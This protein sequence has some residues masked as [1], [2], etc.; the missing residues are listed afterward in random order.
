MSKMLKSLPG[1]IALVMLLPLF[2]QAQAGSGAEDTSAYFPMLRGKKIGVVAN[3]ASEVSGVNI[4]DFL[5]GKGFGIKRIFSPEHGFRSAAEAGQHT[6]D[7]TDPVTGI[8]V[9]SLY[10]QKRKPA[11]SDLDDLDLVVFDIQDVG[12]RFY[13]FISTMLLSMEAAAELHIPFIVLD[14]PNPINGV[15]MEGAILEY[16]R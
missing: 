12:A 3:N 2:T 1:L 5:A 13:T 7:M 6:G 11:P 15:A 10:N 4:V 16:P 8:P 9:V 14:R